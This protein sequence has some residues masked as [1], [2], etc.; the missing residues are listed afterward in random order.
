MVGDTG[1]VREAA[2]RPRRRGRVVRHNRLI[3]K[4]RLAG[5]ILAA[6]VLAAVL[7]SSAS[8]ALFFLFKPTV[9]KPGDRVTVRLGGTSSGF[10]LAKRV[11]PFKPPIRIYLV[12]NGV[13]DNV[14]TRFDRRLHFIG[15]I[16]PDKNTHGSLTFSLPPLDSGAYVAAA[17]CPGCARY[18]AGRTFFVV[19]SPRSRLSVT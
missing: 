18:S 19:P 5:S 6:A 9:A 2:A 1:G 4:R 10:T 14:R 11:K 3:G 17:W 12:R 8:G 13:A 16:V 15:Q 7:V